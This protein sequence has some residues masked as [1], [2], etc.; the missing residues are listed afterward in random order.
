MRQMQHTRVTSA[1]L[2][3]IVVLLIVFLAGNTWAGDDKKKSEKPKYRI[4][5]GV[6]AGY[7]RF[8]TN[9]KFTN[10]DTE[11]SIFVDGEGT[12]GLPKNVGFPV[13]YGFYRFN[14][15]HSI[16]VSYF[17]VN[18]EATLVQFDESRDFHL[19]DLTVAAGAQAEITLTDRSSFTTISYNYTLFDDDRSRLFALVGI[20][21]LD[22]TYGLDAEGEITLQGEPVTSRSYSEEVSVFAPLPMFGLDA[23]FSFSPKWALGTRMALVG[24]TY[25]DVSAL[26]LDTVIRV[27]YQAWKH[28]GFSLGINYFNAGVVIDQPELETEVDYGF[29]GVVLGIDAAF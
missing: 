13:I 5:L 28:V 3:G 25:Q 14:K 11:R 23:W 6:G 15:R 21:G 12:L 20:Y 8:D 18:R 9:F 19:G 24:G 7:G 4:G 2:Y 26:V 10:K 17:G 1:W 27:K 22:L 29:D 16:G